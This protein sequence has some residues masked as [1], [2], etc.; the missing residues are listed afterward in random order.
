MP[1]IVLTKSQAE[2][3]RRL[4]IES[5]SERGAPIQCSDENLGDAQK[6]DATIQV[7]AAI[8]TLLMK[9]ILDMQELLEF[10]ERNML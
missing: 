3:A 5:V 1:E 8:S 4:K 6:P 10:Y 2:P 9:R 7:L